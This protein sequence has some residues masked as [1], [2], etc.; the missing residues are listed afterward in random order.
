PF[1]RPRRAARDWV[2]DTVRV[3]HVEVNQVRSLRKRQVIDST[4]QH[5][6]SGTYWGIA[7]H[8]AD[9]KL[10]DPLPCPRDRVTELARVPT[11][12][13]RLHQDIQER[14]VNWGYGVCDAAM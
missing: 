7:T 9:Y 13:G 2:R 4:K 12:L 3:L 1:K 11:R 6:R 14:L 10:S 8:I 5:A